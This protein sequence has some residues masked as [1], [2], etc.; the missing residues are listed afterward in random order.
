VPEGVSATPRR[1]RPPTALDWNEEKKS[2]PHA[3][4]S[5][6]RQAGGLR[7]HVQQMGEG[8]PIL[9]IHG[10][11]ASTHSWRDLAPLL[12]QRFTV[13]APDLPA[14]AFTERPRSRRLSLSFMAK[15]LAEL[16]ETMPRRPVMAVGHSAGVAILLRCCL[17]GG[18]SPAGIAS[19][20]GALLPFR[21]AAGILFPPLAKLMFLNPLMPRMLA[22]SAGNPERVER[23]IGDT[24]SALDPA[25]I[26]LYARL[27]RRPAQ[28]A[29]ALGMMAHWDLRRL[30]ED[31]DALDLPLLLVAGENDQAIAPA[32]ADRVAEKIGH[33]Q[34]QR[35]PGLGHLAHEEDAAAVGARIIR[36]AEEIG[37]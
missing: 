2:W 11:G 29:A 17:D 8:P 16:I 14:H 22:R 36:F 25:G 9:L 37:V 27:F 5:S 7:W 34:V 33:A 1:G 18:L 23:L 32:E 21:G 4:A 12:A 10:T 24:G 13:I 31:S 3:D 30:A 35:L 19:I 15:A 6:F 26:E 20:N 28:V